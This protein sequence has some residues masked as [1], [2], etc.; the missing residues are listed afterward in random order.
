MSMLKPTYAVLLSCLSAVPAAAQTCAFTT[1]CYE[2]EPCQDTSFALSA[3]LDEAK[4]ITDFG[5][6]V[7][8]GVKSEGSLTTIFATGEGAEY[9]LSRNADAARF[10]THAN[11]G[12]A[13]I[14]YIGTCEGEF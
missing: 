2:A 4:L 3:A 8:V 9:L 11:E 14:T 12:P 6:L 5:D 13:A 1:E 7:V 10:T